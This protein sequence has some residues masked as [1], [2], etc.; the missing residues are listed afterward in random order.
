MIKFRPMASMRDWS[1]RRFVDGLAYYPP[2]GPSLGAIVI[3]EHKR[4]LEPL[5]RLVNREMQRLAPA[6]DLLKIDDREQLITSEGEYAAITRVSGSARSDGQPVEYVYGFVCGDDFYDRFDS[7]CTDATEF[8]PFRITIRDIVFN[9][10]LNLGRDR[11]RR[12]LYD[13][14]KGWQGIARNLITEWYPL[15]Y[16]RRLTRIVVGSAIPEGTPTS[17]VNPHHLAFAR[18]GGLVVTEEPGPV[19]VMSTYGLNG[20]CD[21]LHGEIKGVTDP[22]PT[23]F[24]TVFFQDERYTYPL[25]LETNAADSAAANE[26][27]EAVYKSA[28][29]V[30]YPISRESDLWVAWDKPFA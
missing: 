1:V 3:R 8:P 17:A 16:P 6:L 15:D 10:R 18:P 25:R 4:P 7:Y 30:P 21:A 24:K 29:P 20:S 22:R 28:R 11:A 14:P 5:N 9:H 27:F 13:P 26:V 23:E 2:K 12:F 19:R